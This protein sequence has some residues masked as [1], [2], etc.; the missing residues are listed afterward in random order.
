[1][2]FFFPPGEDFLLEQW[3]MEAL[4]PICCIEQFALLYAQCQ[5]QFTV[6]L[7]QPCELSVMPAVSPTFIIYGI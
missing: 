2:K 7:L 5:K 3:K 4:D 1:M 6:G